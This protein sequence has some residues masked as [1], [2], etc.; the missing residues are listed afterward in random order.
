MITPPGGVLASDAFAKAL[1]AFPEDAAR[2][3]HA[4]LAQGPV[5]DAAMAGEIA[6][7]LG[8]TSS[9]LMLALRP[10]AAAFSNAPLSSSK[11]GAVCRGASGALHLGANLDLPGQ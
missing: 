11:V 8:V 6:R 1:A 7:R 5:I 3:V 4:A 10:V 9:G 2:L